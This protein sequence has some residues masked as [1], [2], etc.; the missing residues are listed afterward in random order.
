[1]QTITLNISPLSIVSFLLFIVL[2]LLLRSSNKNLRLQLKNKELTDE[3]ECRREAEC[4]GKVTR[5]NANGTWQWCYMPYEK[6]KHIE[7]K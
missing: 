4:K 2:M 3:L 1:M 6:P 5:R 7:K